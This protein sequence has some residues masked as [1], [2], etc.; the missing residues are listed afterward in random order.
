MGALNL[1]GG[2]LQA[3]HSPQME[4]VLVGLCDCSQGVEM[5][6]ELNSVM[7]L[8]VVH[9]VAEHL[10][11]R[12]QDAPGMGLEDSGQELTYQRQNSGTS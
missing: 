12:V 8:N 6:Q 4:L 2:S 1:R 5:A 10:Q 7:R 3:T 9:P 11:Q